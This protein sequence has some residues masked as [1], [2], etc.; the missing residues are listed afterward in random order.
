[1]KGNDPEI[2]T[3]QTP[4]PLD[5]RLALLESGHGTSAI[6]L[7]FHIFASSLTRGVSLLEKVYEIFSDLKI[8]RFWDRIC[9]NSKFLAD[10]SEFFIILP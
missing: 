7:Y 9:G 10:F 5:G 1:M 8:L 4:K 6:F 2:D 3:T